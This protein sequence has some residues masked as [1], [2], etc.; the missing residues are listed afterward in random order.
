MEPGHPKLRQAT[1]SVP[2][3]TLTCL[4]ESLS[5][6]PG[7]GMFIFMVHKNDIIKI[8]IIGKATHSKALF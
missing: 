4:I 5:S 1:A 3:S 2:P 7:Q 8:I 6:V